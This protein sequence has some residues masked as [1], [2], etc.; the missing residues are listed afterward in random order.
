MKSTLASV[1]GSLVLLCC[2]TSATAQSTTQTAA[3]PAVQAIS[4]EGASAH[5]YK[6]IDGIDLRLHVFGSEPEMAAKPAIVFF[7]GGGWMQ[8]SVMQFVP[9]SRH[10][11]ERG[12]VAVVA[13]YRVFMRHRTN[14]FAAMRDANSA[15]R[16]L[17][18]NARQL[19]IDPQ[20][21]AAAGGSAGGHLAAAT[22]VL[23]GFQESGEKLAVSSKPNALVLFHPA[24][25]TG[26]LRDSS[27]SEIDRFEGRGEEASPFHNLKAGLPPTMIVHGM[28]DTTVPY[29]HVARYCLAMEELG[30]TCQLFGYPDATHGFFNKGRDDDRWYR[31]TLLEADKFLTDLGYLPA[32]AATHID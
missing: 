6:S 7:F 22:A 11:A 12:M 3:Q 29:S 8:G 23:D 1:L 30:D 15:I 5:I 31:D 16:W 19:G 24:V 32:P 10:L 25:N 4:I 26:E 9:H 21:I 18:Q 28:A 17:R 13:D 20:R 2:T 14:P 27:N